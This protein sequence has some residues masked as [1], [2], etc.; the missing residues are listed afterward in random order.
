[1][2]DTD[3][4]APLLPHRGDGGCVDERVDRNNTSRASPS[5]YIA[6]T[7]EKI[8]KKGDD[9]GMGSRVARAAGRWG[10][11]G[12]ATLATAVCL[13]VAGIVTLHS[14]FSMNL[15]VGQLYFVGL[16]EDEGAANM[17]L[18]MTCY[19]SLAAATHR[20]YVVVPQYASSHYTASSSGEPVMDYAKVRIPEGD[21]AKGLLRHV[22]RLNPAVCVLIRWPRF[23]AGG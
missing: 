7:D 5:L 17:L 11:A 10:C 22:N 2:G 9:G 8:S 18:H 21:E 13:I 19:A 14:H 6:N 1:M 20:T 23:V 16:A 3:E 12:Y 4:C 15:S